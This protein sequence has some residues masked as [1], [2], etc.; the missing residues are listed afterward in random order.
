MSRIV[1][2]EETCGFERVTFESFCSA[3]AVTTVA[4]FLQLNEH[5]RRWGKEYKGHRRGRTAMKP[6]M[7]STL[8]NSKAA[9]AFSRLNLSAWVLEETMGP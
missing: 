8:L 3:L 4:S 7:S 1:L 6:G 2:S 9:V 5:H